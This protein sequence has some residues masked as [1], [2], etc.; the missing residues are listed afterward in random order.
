MDSEQIKLAPIVLSH[1]ISIAVADG[2]RVVAA[3][4]TPLPHS[5]KIPLTTDGNISAIRVRI[6]EGALPACEIVIQLPAALPAGSTI[7]LTLTIHEDFQIDGCAYVPALNQ[8]RTAEVQ[9]MRGDPS[10]A[11]DV[12]DRV[13]FLRERSRDRT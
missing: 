12:V 6:F 11:N 7:D 8:V 10:S 5:V 13:Q 2:L 3:E 4:G 9:M 1:S